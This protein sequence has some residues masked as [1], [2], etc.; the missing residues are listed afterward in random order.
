MMPTDA[1]HDPAVLNVPGPRASALVAR[2]EAVFAPCMGRVY[3]LVME[4]G[5]GCDVWDA[6]GQRYLDMNAGIAVVAAGHS[7]PRVVSAIQEQAARFCHMAAT[8]FYNEPMIRLG[9]RLVATMPADQQW[10]VFLSNSGTE[11]VEA[12]IKL[13]R[14]ATRRTGVVAFYGAFHGR[15]YGSMSLTA[16]KAVQRRHYGP[17]LPGVFHA[18]YA[19]PY[20]PPFGVPTERTTAACLEYIEQTLLRTVAPPEDIAAIV[21]EPIQGEGGYVVPSAGFLCGLRQICDRYGIVLVFDEV[22]S[23]IGR[24]GTMWAHEQDQP[25]GRCGHCAGQH[26]T[27]DI[28]VSAKGL[29]GGLPIGAIIARRALTERWT[30]GAHGSTYSGNALSCAAANVVLDLVRDGLADNAR[31]VGAH[32]MRGLA[33]L[34]Q[35]YPVIGDVRGRGLMI[36]IEFVS[37]RGS[38]APDHDLAEAVM[39]QAFRRGVLLL[40]CGESTIRLCPPLVLTATQADEALNVLEASIRAVA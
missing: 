37:D 20:R 28:V 40:T 38:R 21:V 30:P 6:D 3:P 14:L 10:H 35:R 13:A 25:V 34:H 27:P 12:A 4:R 16:S 9:E 2:D 15:S 22:Q 24:T 23:G 26:C 33:T 17:M 8:D 5:L 39:L 36:G 19:N 32:L 7:H 1:L 11:A 18:F 31:A 29:G